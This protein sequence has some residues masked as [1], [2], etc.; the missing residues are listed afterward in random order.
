MKPKYLTIGPT[1]EEVL[2][3]RATHKCRNPILPTLFAPEMCAIRKQKSHTPLSGLYPYWYCEDCEG[4]ILRD[5][6][7]PPKTP[8]PIK[9]PNT[10]EPQMIGEKR[11][12]HCGL[13]KHIKKFYAHKKSRDGRQSWCIECQLGAVPTRREKKSAQNKEELSQLRD[14]RISK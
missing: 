11:C 5:D 14:F 8:K 7:I 13:T 3:Q 1:Q 9:Q 12:P 10:Y 4:P 6:P 2:S